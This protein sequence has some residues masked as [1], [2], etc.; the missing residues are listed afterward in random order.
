M[1]STLGTWIKG[2]TFSLLFGGPPRSLF[3]PP[4]L[5]FLWNQNIRF[6]KSV[7]LGK[8]AKH[9]QNGIIFWDPHFLPPGLFFLKN[10]VTPH[11]SLFR[12]PSKVQVPR[13]L[14]FPHHDEPSSLMRKAAFEFKLVLVL[15]M[16]EGRVKKLCL[17]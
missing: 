10:A 15:T 14:C 13:V 7:I 8:N 6:I 12:P 9:W 16:V 17:S 11:P 2:G 1:G 3:W 4:C 5:F